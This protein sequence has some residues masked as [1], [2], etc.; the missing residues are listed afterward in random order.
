MTRR[1][2]AQAARTGKGAWWLGAALAVAASAAAVARGAGGV[3][4]DGA[5][6]VVAAV[7][8][9]PRALARLAGLQDGDCIWRRLGSPE[10]PRRRRLAQV[11]R[12]VTASSA[13]A[14]ASA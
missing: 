2:L 6:P 4:G 10:C 3:T 1:A 7:A 8:A 5:A 13:V 9:R 12:V 11:V 14:V